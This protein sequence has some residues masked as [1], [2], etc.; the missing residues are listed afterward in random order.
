MENIPK[1][2]KLI[3]GNVPRDAIHIAVAPV[4]AAE[5]L[6]PGAHVGLVAGRASELAKPLIGVVD[7]FLKRAV[8][9]GQQFYL[10]LYQGTITSLRH[11]W[12][13]PAF[14]NTDD[15]KIR[16]AKEWITSWANIWGEDYETVVMH[17]NA[18]LDSGDY[19]SEGG[20]FES[21]SVPDEFWTHFERATG[22]SVEHDERGSFFSCSC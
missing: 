2:G 5:L 1:L 11:E 21:E 8:A 6:Q 16:A 14:A 3:E 22:R 7:P 20:R 15:E 18:Y 9:E 10:F 19:W 4:V 12:V 13:H 17:A